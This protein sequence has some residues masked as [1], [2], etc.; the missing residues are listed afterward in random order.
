[1][2]KMNQKIIPFEF[3]SRIE[4]YSPYSMNELWAVAYYKYFQ[5]FLQR[6]L[7]SQN[8]LLKKKFHRKITF[9]NVEIHIEFFILK[10]ENRKVQSVE[11]CLSHHFQ[12]YLDVEKYMCMYMFLINYFIM[13][14]VN[15]ILNPIKHDTLGIRICFL[16][17]PST[18]EK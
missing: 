4:A 2:E 1:M 3:V 6:M 9:I 14:L 10:T 12:I 17:K 16:T 11:L 15:L 18:S 5:R 13:P 8:A 7:I